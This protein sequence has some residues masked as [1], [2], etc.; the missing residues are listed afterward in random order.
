M[1]NCVGGKSVASWKRKLL[2]HQELADY[3]TIRANV[4]AL[5]K[6]YVQQ[7]AIKLINQLRSDIVTHYLSERNRRVGPLLMS[8]VLT[9]PSEIQWVFFAVML[10]ENLPNYQ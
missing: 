5:S 2:G 4:S 1:D 9:A 8:L 6:G 3:T 10:E 7:M